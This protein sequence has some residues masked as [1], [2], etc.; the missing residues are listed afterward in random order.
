MLGSFS[1]EPVSSQKHLSVICLGIISRARLSAPY[2]QVQHSRHGAHKIGPEK[3]RMVGSYVLTKSIATRR[4]PLPSDKISGGVRACSPESEAEHV[5]YA[6]NTPRFHGSDSACRHD[7]RLVG[8]EL[9]AGNVDTPIDFL[10]PLSVHQCSVR[11]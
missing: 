4:R 1:T 6:A 8:L 10:L 5:H 7:V 11:S 9:H 2:D 3:S